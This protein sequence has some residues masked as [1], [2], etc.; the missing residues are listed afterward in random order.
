MFIYIR[1]IHVQSE[2]GHERLAPNVLYY[3]R[4]FGAGDIFV[5]PLCVH[6]NI[7][8]HLVHIRLINWKHFFNK[9][10]TDIEQIV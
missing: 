2:S 8:V 3:L 7:Q 4:L 1:P 5:R 10:F 9:D 6:R